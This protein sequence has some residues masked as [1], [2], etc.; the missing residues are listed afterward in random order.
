M[1]KSL[2]GALSILGVIIYRTLWIVAVAMKNSAY[3]S[4]GCSLSHVAILGLGLLW[5]IRYVGSD[6]RSLVLFG[7]TQLMLLGTDL[8]FVDGIAALVVSTLG[9]ATVAI[10]CWL[11]K[12]FQT[13]LNAQLLLVLGLTVWE[14]GVGLVGT[15]KPVNWGLSLYGIGSLIFL[16]SFYLMACSNSAKERVSVRR[17]R[18][19]YESTV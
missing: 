14:G 5:F 17:Q 3:A 1:G 2:S 19:G 9:S 6:R 12:A 16:F 4:F 13:S 18:R 11:V 8:V 10:S 15:G 7:G